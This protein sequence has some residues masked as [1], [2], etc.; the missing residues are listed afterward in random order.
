VIPERPLDRVGSIKL[1]LGLLVAASILVATAV[2]G[3]GE[4][5][6]V[7]WWL[8]LPVTLAAALGITQW[9]ARGMT[10]PLRE[11][12][13]VARRMAAGD[14][15]QRVT[16][17]S[18]DEVG[19]LARA[20]NTMA[21][22]LG[23]VDEQRRQL[24]ATV[25]HELRT[26]LAAQRALL[27]NLVDGVAAPDP[28][29]LGAALAQAERM[30][31]L[32]TDLLDLSRIDAG[33]ARL[34]VEPVPVAELL[35]RCVAEAGLTQR[36]VRHEVLVEPADLVVEADPAR[37]V[38]VVANLLDNAGRHSPAEGAVRVSAYAVA[39][40]RWALEV[41][42]E[43]PG[44]PPASAEAVFERFGTG[45][46]DAGGTG[47]GLAIAR[48]VCEL[49]GGTV[50]AVP[51]AHDRSGAVIRAVL[52]RHTP[53][54]AHPDSPAVE[55][56]PPAPP[57]VPQRQPVPIQESPMPATP[58]AA[59]PPTPAP[60]HLFAPP[61]PPADVL[62]EVWPEAGIGPQVGLLGAA[63]VVGLA[64]A[65]LMPYHPIGAG[66]LLTLLAGGAV[67]WWASR[68]R[69]RPWA[70]GCAGLAVGLGTLVVLR[71]SAW[72]AVL[73]VLVA[74]LLV[75]AAVTDAHRLLAIVAGPFAW[76]LSALRGLPLLGRTLTAMSRRRHLW[77][78][79]RTAAI[80]VVLVVAFGSLFAS[81][82]AVFGA[83]TDAVVPNLDLSGVTLRTFVAVLVGG[84]VLSGSYLAVNPPRVDVL[85]PPP[86]RPV[87][88][89]WEWLVPVGLVLAVFVAFLLAQAAALMG[90]HDYVQRTTGLTYAD[91]V[92]EGFG[93]LTVAT[94]LTLLVVAVT[95]RKAPVA[96]A[97]DRL[98]L[99]SMLGAL[100]AM[101]L[102]VVASALHK[103][104]TYQEAYGFTTLRLLVDAFE[105]WL[106]LVV[107]LVL[108]AGV[109]LRGG[110][111]PRAA[112][113]SGASVLLV[114]GLM[115]PDGWVAQ[116]NVD[117]F[118]AGATL[119]TVY[120]G[121][122]GEDAIPTIVRAGLPADLTGCLVG[123]ATSTGNALASQ[124]GDPL[125]WNI[126][127]SRA[128]AAADAVTVLDPGSPTCAALF[129]PAEPLSP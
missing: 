11:M 51:P 124:G 81:G 45:S 82:D 96:T 93:Q 13:A 116:Q 16:A 35:A 26:P 69:T 44:I 14:N 63:L 111:L 7:P 53:G 50:A 70:V 32:V 105:V 39:G 109:R 55:P 101:T 52:P 47:L 115:N 114:L 37:L 129:H 99:R 34:R 112:L 125:G 72:L 3:I 92:H 33:Q 91:Y 113:L 88:R 79:L 87:A 31:D 100:G 120:L 56:R 58:A 71:A 46:D 21:A 86:A 19:G 10:S 30:S 8:S 89:S 74:G 15:S 104:A 73:A 75:A 127:R 67:I 119:D 5:A 84:I 62:G 43:G 128:A 27:E 77:P 23:A 20:F 18:T 28:A 12:T 57:H 117:R 90:G 24:I 98:L 59:A 54:A 76:V 95:A 17:T 2:A 64:G 103:M 126:G 80:S 29:S 107:V 1:K 110:W 9:L 61:T 49:H 118:R 25:S 22:D 122:L 40:D 102:V 68:Y 48:W 97:A 65:L 41:A 123:A 42:D 94:V 85:Q 78:V 106:G 6:E 108:V 83:W 36:A 60:A 66:V 121:A 38:Q 4:Q